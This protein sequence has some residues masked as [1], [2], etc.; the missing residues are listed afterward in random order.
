M[1]KTQ[2]IIIVEVQWDDL[3]VVSTV[4]VVLHAAKYVNV[5][6]FVRTNSHWIGALNDSHLG[7]RGSIMIGGFTVRQLEL[8]L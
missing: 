5:P 2:S 6:G 1:D 4:T 3:R 7:L 8:D